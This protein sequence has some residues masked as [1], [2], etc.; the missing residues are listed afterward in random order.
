MF[1]LFKLAWYGIPTAAMMWVQCPNAPLFTNSATPPL[2]KTEA[3]KRFA[4]ELKGKVDHHEKIV[5][6]E[7]QIEQ[8][9]ATIRAMH[10]VYTTMQ[11]DEAR[12][13][14]ARARAQEARDE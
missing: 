7:A 6:K 10:S 1:A 12:L 9:S 11:Q 2:F 5:S 14:E 8:A 13:N 4:N 3:F